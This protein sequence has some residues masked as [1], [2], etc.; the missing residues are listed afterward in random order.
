VKLIKTT[1]EGSWYEV[2]FCTPDDALVVR[3]VLSFFYIQNL[4]Q[5]VK[6]PSD[7]LLRD[8]TKLL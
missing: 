6:S 5:F 1:K 3:N 7:T 4:S 8:F 2:H